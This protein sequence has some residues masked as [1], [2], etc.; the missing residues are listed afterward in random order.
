MT[1]NEMAK[2]FDAIV[3][4]AGIDKFLDTPIKYYSSG[5]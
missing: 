4:F 1:R 3:E 5:I 2:K